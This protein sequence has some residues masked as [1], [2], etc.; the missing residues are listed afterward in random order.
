MYVLIIL[1]LVVLKFYSVYVCQII[2][3]YTLNIYNYVCQ[4]F[5]S[6]V[7]KDNLW[8]ENFFKFLEIRMIPYYMIVLIISATLLET[9]ALCC[10]LK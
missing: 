9:R 5:I 4:L 2:T 7:E 10:D 6:K 1:I 8:K 3:L